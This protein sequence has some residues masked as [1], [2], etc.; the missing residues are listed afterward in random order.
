MSGPAP[1]GSN[2]GPSARQV[3]RAEG[4]FAYGVIG[5]D[6]H[7]FGDGR[8]VYVLRNW[9]GAPES[10][11]EWLRELPSRMLSARHEVVPFTGR[12]HDL[13]ELRGWRDAPRRLSARWLHGPGGQGK[14]R[15]AAR[16]AA[17]SAAEGWL[18]V[19][20]VRGPG[21]VLPPPGSQDLRAENA[22]GVLL[23]V[24]YADH[25]PL[26]DLSW[27]LSNALLH[28]DALPARVLLLARD[29]TMWPAVRATLADVQAA[30]SRQTLEPLAGEG[31][32]EEEGEPGRDD[33]TGMF[34][35]ARDA[36][37]ARY[38]LPAPETVGPPVPLA[39]P[40]FGL[41]LTVHMAALAAVDAHRDGRH[42]PTD[43]AGLTTYLLDREQR[44]W[45]RLSDTPGHR[46]P[47]AIMNRAVFAAALTGAVERPT[48]T[49]AV[50]SLGLPL[51]A[52]TVL[53]DHAVC[54]PPTGSTE[55]P[56]PADLAPGTVLEP[57]TPDRLAEDFVALTLPG[58]VADYPAYD[59]APSALNALLPHTDRASP[60]PWLPRAVT[61]LA[62]GA[63]RWPHLGTLH[64][65][66]LLR[67]APWL[68]VA[69][70][71]AALGTLVS[72]DDIDIGLLE[73]INAYLPRRDDADLD[74]AA[75]VLAVRLAEHWLAVTDDPAEQA[76]V[77]LNLGWSL[78]GAGR[79]DE[80]LA[81]EERAVALYRDLA[82]AEPA[83][84]EAD[85]AR[86]LNNHA[87]SLSRERRYDEAV[88]AME[89]AVELRRRRLR[90]DQ[91]ADIADLALSL[92]NYSNN[93]GRVGRWL[94]A[95][96]VDGEALELYAGLAASRPGEYGG[97]LAITLLNFGSSLS[98]AL[99]LDAALAATRRAVF[100]LRPLA[101]SAPAAHEGGL[102]RALTNK[103]Q[104]L[105]DVGKPQ[106]DLIRN[107]GLSPSE[108][109]FR[110]S[111]WRGEALEA[112][113]EAVEIGRR[114]A[115]ANPAALDADLAGALQV[116]ST[117]QQAIGMPEEARTT[118][119]EAAVFEER[120]DPRRRTHGAPERVE[121][122]QGTYDVAED[123]VIVLYRHLRVAEL[124]VHGPE[125]AVLLRSRA[126]RGPTPDLDTLAEALEI[127]LRLADADP[128]THEPAYFMELKQFGWE[129]WWA[130]RRSE[131]VETME[132]A[133]DLARA[134]TTE[135]R[136]EYGER[137]LWV[138]DSLAT[139]L[140]GVGR[141]REA[142][143]VRRLAKRH[144]AT[145]DR[146]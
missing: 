15:L 121:Y 82:R 46:T 102:A 92:S 113:A 63:A 56:G 70:G 81:A 128:V 55:P 36:F 146:A 22:A 85:L 84:Y 69:A 43:A 26:P 30:T 64:L 2:P 116:L 1:N 103:A 53:A 41:T 118:A 115:R 54:Y 3:V 112:A 42:P 117:V 89:S 8:P 142:R 74:P 126:R 7:V 38:G 14:S 37:A 13:A 137:L 98:S 71:G 119:R 45:A 25:W 107:H 49:V 52:E 125:L 110:T 88:R 11:P 24:D 18:V 140:K 57:L 94:E 83:V 12:A 139:M 39:G 138:A 86:A 87:G 50:T 29:T 79:Y 10:D 75:A 34:R 143:E 141:R 95:L 28:H 90:P 124:T 131:A 27:L 16:L 66:P 144:L 61:V 17:E 47:P 59:W 78:G 33:R 21:T 120:S 9:R 68:A 91:H 35:A 129:L 72:L 5:A 48:G 111:G 23:I 101:R 145:L 123:A 100:M 44:H 99:R 132:Q 122:G 65:Y 127:G 136:E 97:D 62:S 108:D 51:P 109:L 77:H 133:L 135:D 60:A 19:A 134:L 73:Q 106:E 114:R 67:E 4:G 104:M 40:E 20:A 6:I 76:V 32:G 58:H 105:V 130:G 31:E 93:L 80:S 96:T